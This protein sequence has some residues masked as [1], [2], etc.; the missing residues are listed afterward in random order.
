M[1]RCVDEH[2]VGLAGVDRPRDPPTVVGQPDRRPAMHAGEH[3]TAQRDRGT[4]RGQAER[5]VDADGRCALVVPLDRYAVGGRQERRAHRRRYPNR[6]GAGDVDEAAADDRAAAGRMGSHP[7]GE[8]P[9]RLVRVDQRVDQQPASDGG[10]HC[11][12]AHD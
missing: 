10:L 2:G 1:R 6:P 11:L 4:G 7:V 9:G 5:D 12:S 3:T 8:M